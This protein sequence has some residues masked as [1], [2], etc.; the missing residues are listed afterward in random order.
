[1]PASKNKK[2]L[3]P[4]GVIFDIKNKIFKAGKILKPYKIVVTGSHGFDSTS[5]KLLL[6]LK[7]DVVGIDSLND[8]YDVKLK[9]DRGKILLS[10]PIM[11]S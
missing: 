4:S 3:S 11:N 1:M 7:Y 9:E 2:I 10:Y 8:Y 6:E 5:Q